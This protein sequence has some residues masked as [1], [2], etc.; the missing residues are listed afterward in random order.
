MEIRIS[1]CMIVR[2]EEQNIRR[3]LNS[4]LGAVDEIIVIDTGSSDATC[5]I[6]K[7][8][9]AIVQSFIWNDNFSA[10]RNMSLELASGDWILFLDADEELDAGSAAMLRQLCRDAAVDGYFI[11]IINYL[12]SEG[13]LDLAPDLVF[14]LFRNRPD[15]RFHGAIHEQIVDVILEKNQQ[16][17]YKIA[18]EIV[19]LHYG[20]LDEQIEA[21][22]KKQRNLKLI[23]CE[24]A[25]NP[26]NQ[27]LRYHYGVELYRAQLYE[28]A[29]AELIKAANGLDPQ[30]IYLPKLLR[31]I[32]LACHAAHNTEQALAVI[33]HSL[34]LFPN[35]ADLY[36]YQGLAHY[37][38]K[39]YGLA[40]AAFRLALSMP[41]QPAYYASFSGVRGFRSY[42]C[43]GQIAEKF[44][45]QEEALHC[46][47]LSLRDNPRFSAALEAITRLLEAR[48]DPAYAG[49]A[50]GKI[51][52]FC[53][54]QANLLMARILF[55]QQAFRLALEYVNKSETQSE[56][57]PDF[58]LWKAIC[59]MQERRFF[60]ALRIIEAFAAE[61][62]L[63]PLAKLNKLLCFGLQENKPKV[64]IIADELYNL[65]LSQDTGAVIG[66]IRNALTG[67][68]APKTYLGD[69]GTALLRDILVRIMDLGEWEKA[70]ALLAGLSGQWLNENCLDIGQ[71][72]FRYGNT[73]A[74][75]RYL[76]LC[77]ETNRCAEAYELLAEIKQKSGSHLEASEF[78]RQAIA[79]E[80]KEPLYYIKLIKTYET[81][82]CNVLLEAAAQ[83][84]DSPCFTQLLKAGLQH[85]GNN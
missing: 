9:G 80:P 18:E 36:Y 39:D 19:I 77:L 66:I 61:H 11:K 65:G 60:E 6:A 16:A 85:D 10:A 41:E 44:A 35:Y 29:A 47:I 63:Y 17:S 46:Y 33:E 21:K 57:A 75:E 25:A 2:N 45:N 3:C 69:E 5:Q 68:A 73:A 31:Y 70:E 67:A 72:Y 71:L 23:Q 79:L 4:M 56:T 59:L 83:H 53:S 30:T 50:L 24:V 81:M 20:Y 7:E 82:R 84:P 76:N 14:R 37:E 38:N 62:P 15:Y 52:D 12:G 48:E 54:P 28:Q 34:R 58:A 64:R 26:G 78:F 1:L 74:A 51:C 40:Y 43:L 55:R 13:W 49:D 42:Y 32:V 22:D 27:L 8:Y